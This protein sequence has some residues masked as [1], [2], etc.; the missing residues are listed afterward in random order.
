MKLNTQNFENGMQVEGYGPGF[1]RVTGH[2]HHG[3][4][5]IS[6]TSAMPWG[7]WDDLDPI[8]ALGGQ[9]DVLLVGT[10][11]DVAPFPPAFRALLTRHDLWADPMAT[12]AALR[13]Y[14][15]LLAEARRV[16]LAVLPVGQPN[17]PESGD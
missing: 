14:N 13:T 2:L 1:F 10:G 6:P 5:I 15:V 12:P 16:A 11:A 3:P 9:V 17:P 7:G 4:M 8:V